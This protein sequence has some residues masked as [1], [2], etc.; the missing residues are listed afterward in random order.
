M[1]MVGRGTA[2]RDV[3]SILGA[4]AGQEV[5][6]RQRLQLLDGVPAVISTS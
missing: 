1:L 3:T 6:I 4:E 2:P 5:V